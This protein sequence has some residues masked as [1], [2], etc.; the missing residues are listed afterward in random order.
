M[1][2]KTR[3]TQIA[4]FTAV[5]VALA[6]SPAFA[7]EVVK[8]GYFIIDVIFVIA[9]GRAFRTREG[10]RR[11]AERRHGDRRHSRPD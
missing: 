6:A 5:G 7:Q 8:I 4:A 9:T 3:M 2:L 1:S 11:M 10:S